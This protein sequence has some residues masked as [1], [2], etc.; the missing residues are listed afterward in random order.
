[1]RRVLMAAAC[2]LALAPLAAWAGKGDD[3]LNAAFSN[4]VTTLDNYKETG[5]EGLVIARLIY[6]NL[7]YKDFDSGE[8]VPAL[9]SSYAFADDRTIDFII[10]DGVKFHDGTTLTA[11]DVVY[12]LN[13]VSSK[14]YDAR[15][16]VAVNWIEKAEKTGDDKVRLTMK[17]P[18]PLALEMLAGNLPIYPKAYYE[19]VGSEGMSVKP[20]GTGPYRMVEVTPGT[21]FVMERFEDH[22]AGS[23]KG[24]PAIGNVVI[25]VLPEANT[26]YAEMLNGQL[27]WIWKI[28]PDEAKKLGR[29]DRIEIKHAA[30]MRVAY[31]NLNPAFQDGKSPLADVRVRQA[32]HHAIN[33]EAIQKA[34]VGE[35]SK[36]VHAVC[37]PIQFG[38]T[39]DVAKYPYDPEK[40]KALM[41]EAGYADGFP[42]ELV[43]A[44][45]PRPQV[46]AIA[47]DLGKIGIDVTVNEQ[48]WASAADL[49]RSG[50]A[51][52]A[53]ANWG[54]YG[55]GDVGLTTSHYF[56]D[57]DENH[58]KDREVIDWLATGDTSVDPKVRQEAYAKALRKISEGAYWV[59]LWTFN[60]IYAINKDLS[61]ELSPD[62]FARFF[63]A[64]WK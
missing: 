49:W 30:I 29:S 26:Q 36:L 21:R 62:E 2:A 8:I 5:R 40:A 43:V 37:N 59:P 47:A 42:I 64:R 18:Y 51:P 58:V 56:G 19:K 7:L 33:R 13:L 35:A 4:E 6:D 54:S 32:I 22:Y 50:K 12:T 63:K 20:V 3:T 10:R 38:C 31:I 14:E 28:P 61:F 45:T 55:I 11:D 9:A 15:Y 17:S 46:E 25:R 24:K 60:V 52:M 27:D 57:T 16:Q 41:K 23:P 48:Q 44:S 39:D 34:F 1:M 53:M